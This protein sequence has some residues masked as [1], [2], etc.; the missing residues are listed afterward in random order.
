MRKLTSSLLVLFTVSLALALEPGDLVITEI[1]QNPAAVSDA[2]GEWFELYNAT[3][4]TVNLNGLTFTEDG[5]GNTFVIAVDVPVDAGSYAL[6]SNNGDPSTNGGLPTVDYV[7]PGGYYLGNSVDEVIIID[8]DGETIIDEVWYDNGA[9]F[10]DPNGASMA[11][12]SDQYDNNNVGS[13]WYEE[14]TYTYGLG[15]YGTPRSPN[16][17]VGFP[18][19][20]DVTQNPSNPGSSDDV[21]ISATV[22]DPEV[23]TLVDVNLIYDVD[24]GPENTLAMS[25][26]GDIYSEMIPA[27]AGGA[28]VTWR[29]EATD[30]MDQTTTYM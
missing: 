21:D 29:I 23:R 19:I 30:D 22:T 3:D 1:M 12:L 20:S 25:A 16:S 9:T 11:L 28:V 6:L 17:L 14:I 13:S 27:Q 8:G 5:G 18:V 2:N 7:Y 26:A 4:G 24:G 15:D 10:P